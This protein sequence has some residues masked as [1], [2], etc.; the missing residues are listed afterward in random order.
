MKA[1]AQI[2][3]IKLIITSRK[4]N[5]DYS[6]YFAVAKIILSKTNWAT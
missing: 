1:Y 4:T 2:E 6:N 3:N 5:T